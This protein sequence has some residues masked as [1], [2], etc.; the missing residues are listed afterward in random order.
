MLD[1]D[2]GVVI[3]YDNQNEELGHSIFTANDLSGRE[4]DY[5]HDTGSIILLH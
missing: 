4:E 1:W 2:E 3:Q 5:C